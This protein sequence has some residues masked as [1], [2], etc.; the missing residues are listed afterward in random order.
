MRNLARDFESDA[1]AGLA[2][3]D[4]DI[5]IRFVPKGVASTGSVDA[6]SSRRSQVVA[7]LSASVMVTGCRGST[8]RRL[9]DQSRSADGRAGKAFV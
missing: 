6:Q 3:E 7:D 9:A 5:A 8:A 2:L 1:F 4:K